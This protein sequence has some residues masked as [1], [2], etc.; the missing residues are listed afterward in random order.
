MK[1]RNLWIAAASIVMFAACESPEEETPIPD[2]IGLDA[3]ELNAEF[4]GKTQTVTVT[5]TCDWTVETVDWIDVSPASGSKGITEVEVKVLPNEGDARNHTLV[6]AASK[7]VKAELKV[8]QD[9]FVPAPVLSVANPTVE[10]AAD[11]TSASIA[12]TSNVAWTAASDNTAFTLDPAS[13][14]GNA[15]IAV[16]F[17][18]N[19]VESPV[20]AKVTLT[21]EGVT[22]V[23][24]TITQAAYVAPAV[25]SVD[26]TSIDVAADATSASIAVTSN[27]AWTA[28]SDNT[29][30]TLDPASGTGNATIAVSFPANT[31]ESPVVA[32]VTLTAEGVNPVEVTVTQAAAAP[33]VPD[34]ESGYYE[35]TEE[36]ADWTG[37]YLIVYEGPNYD[38]TEIS[39]V[40]NGNTTK[41]NSN[42]ASVVTINNGFISKSDDV[43]DKVFKIAAMDGGYSI[44]AASGVYICYEK[45]GTQC[46]SSDVPV[47]NTISCDSENGLMIVPNNKT[48]KSLQFINTETGQVFRYCDH[49]TKMPI[50]LFKYEE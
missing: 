4:T 1:L 45:G 50:K 32:K 37:T 18:A 6:F 12:V 39:K 7:D 34:K 33:V 36:L 25:L 46:T 35:V 42:K 9:K 8:N 31:V 10:V 40:M 17:P 22:P 26:R 30:F 49:G 13:G 27:V 41:F 48:T 47:A 21:A 23:E 2:S 11:A 24:V 28:A 38:G 5:S 15:T 29:A 43:D 20:V 16:S 44:Q 19:T 3:K 14:T